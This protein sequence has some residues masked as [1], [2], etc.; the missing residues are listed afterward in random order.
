MISERT[1]KLLIG[2]AALLALGSSAARAQDSAQAF[3]VTGIDVNFVGKTSMD[4]RYAAYRYAQRQAWKQLYARLAGGSPAAAP[5]MNDAALDGMVDG[6]AI[7]AERFSDKRY[8]A[9][10]GVVFDRTRA[11]K[12]LGHGMTVVTSPPMLLLPVLDDGGSR[13]VYEG[14]SPWLKAWARYQPGETPMQYVRADGTSGD[15]V[16]LNAYQTRRADRKQW[17]SILNRY[18]ASDV[19][20]AEAKLYRSYPGGAVVGL[21]TARHGPD[22]TVLARVR[23]RTGSAAG[24]DGLLDAGVRAIDA[25]YGNALRAGA[26]RSDP[27]LMEALAP[28]EE[29]APT[30][31]PVN[32]GGVEANVAT[33]DGAT[34]SAIERELRA[35]PGVIGVSLSS[36]SIG[37]TSKVRIRTSE[38][39]DWLAYNLDQRGLRIEPGPY[40]TRLRRKVATDVP[41]A[42]PVTPEE[43]E[44]AAEAATGA[45]PKPATPP[46]A[47][48]ARPV[49]P[50]AAGP[51]KTPAAKAAAAPAKPPKGPA[52]LLPV[53]K[54]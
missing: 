35:T 13:T 42:R 29:V 17:A 1:L 19:L 36:L 47:G 25:A 48:A 41:V 38:G 26:L 46:A 18:G 7:E 4:A 33:P 11:S 24:L 8:I 20:I 21:F 45:A 16:L 39:Y 50:S 22:G 30:L 3:T 12:Y 23:L 53:P 37:G 15:T 10:L 27:V 14:R 52:N 44:A 34:W 49:A 40:G 32:V 5:G 43:M 31:A 6:I 9:R 54:E 51:P 2:L 28:D